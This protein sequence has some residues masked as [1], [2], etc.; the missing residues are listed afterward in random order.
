MLT[1]PRPIP[2]SQCRTAL[3]AL[4]AVGLANCTA[5]E[6]GAEYNDPFETANRAVHED[7]K[8]IDRFLFG[9]AGKRGVV[10]VLPR[11]VAQ[12]LGNIANNLGEPSDV[13]NSLLQGRVDSAI[14]DSFL[15]L[16]ISSVGI[17]GLFDPA[18]ALGIAAN[19]TDFGETMAVWGIRE[20]A[21]L[22]LPIA[23]PST[24]RDALGKV[25]DFALDPI[26]QVIG[27]SE[28]G[29]VLA[30]R[31]GSAVGSRQRFSDTVESILY[32]SADS[33]AQSRLLYLQNRRF[34]LGEETQEFDP[35]ED[36]YAE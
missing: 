3:A 19:D 26:G 13:A 35:Y 22:E 23:G 16:I 2:V 12:G 34:E 33:Y 5:P 8:A 9:G 6:P 29:A 20:G 4:L 25:V 27:G 14:T 36:P 32:E 18:T 7:N 1:R 30:A 10:P 31:I 15:F 21:Y 28:Q 24:E 11:P 17:A